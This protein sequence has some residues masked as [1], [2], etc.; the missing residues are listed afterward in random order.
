M[1][2]YRNDLLGD[3]VFELARSHVFLLIGSVKAVDDVVGS[4]GRQQL[5][6]NN[7]PCAFRLASVGNRLKH[8]LTSRLAFLYWFGVIVSHSW[9][10]LLEVNVNGDRLHKVK[11][12]LLIEGQ[13]EFSF[14]FQL[15]SS[16]VLLNC[17]WVVLARPNLYRRIHRLLLSWDLESVWLWNETIEH[18]S[19][20]EAFNWLVFIDGLMVVVCSWA[21]FSIKVLFQF[22]FGIKP[23]LLNAKLLLLLSFAACL[24]KARKRSIGRQGW[25]SKDWTFS[26]CLVLAWASFKTSVGSITSW[27]GLLFIDQD[28]L[29][30]SGYRALG[31]S[32]AHHGERL[33]GWSVHLSLGVSA[34]RFWCFLLWVHHLGLARVNKYIRHHLLLLLHL[35]HLLD[36]GGLWV[37]KHGSVNTAGRQWRLIMLLYRSQ[38]RIILSHITWSLSAVVCNYLVV[39]VGGVEAWFYCQI[40]RWYIH[41]LIR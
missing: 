26:T 20:A 22:N 2:V 39:C 13:A 17:L 1:K 35:H 36:V 11:R 37:L 18:A 25:S 3:G 38:I 6:L 19:L 23:S 5:I 24:S 12:V 16:N 4:W 9:I 41:I 14:W 8:A 15:G 31:G 10:C 40:H 29:H 34:A 30:A 32:I 7:L 33:T 21:R 27:K 28:S